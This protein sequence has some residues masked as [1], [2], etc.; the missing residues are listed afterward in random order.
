VSSDVVEV[1]PQKR[2]VRLVA[3]GIGLVLLLLG[4]VIG[5]DDDFPFGPFRMYSTSSSTTGVITTVSIEVR[6]A[7]G[8]WED[9]SA[10]PS[11]IGM[12]AAEVEGQLSRFEADSDR[13]AAIARSYNNLHPDAEPVTGVRIISHGTVVK[14]RIPTGETTEAVLAQWEAP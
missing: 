11:T 2:T 7:D 6:M 5:N 3:T 13:L 14:D 9:F 8:P 10:T 1:S 4:T 12:N